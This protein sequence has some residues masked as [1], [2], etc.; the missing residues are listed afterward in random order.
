MPRT[1]GYTNGYTLPND[2]SFLNVYLNGGTY[3]EIHL[4]GWYNKTILDSEKK[5][6]NDNSIWNIGPVSTSN[7][8]LEE[9]INEEKYYQWVGKVGIISITE[10]VRASNNSKCTSVYDYYENRNCYN[11]GKTHNYLYSENA[12][13]SINR[14]SDSRI[15]NY[16]YYVWF[17]PKMW[18]DNISY[19]PTYVELEVNPV[20]YLK[21]SILLIGDGTEENPYKIS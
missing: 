7:Q 2:E 8:S 16:P 15:E 9:C 17:L 5:Y 4:E 6:I 19:A 13:W 20:I 21:D 3:S 18:D 1:V 14:P 10:F 11:N 12:K